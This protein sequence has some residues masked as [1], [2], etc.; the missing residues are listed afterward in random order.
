MPLLKRSVLYVFI[1]LRCTESVFV[2][3]TSCLRTKYI[4]II[5]RQLKLRHTI[6]DYNWNLIEPFVYVA[7]Q[8]VTQKTQDGIQ[9]NKKLMSCDENVRQ[10]LSLQKKHSYRLSVVVSA[11]FCSG[12]SVFCVLYLRF[13]NEFAEGA[14]HKQK[15]SHPLPSTPIIH[16]S[17][18]GW[19]NTT[20]LHATTLLKHV[21]A[22]AIV[23]KYRN[24]AFILLLVNCRS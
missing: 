22:I 19:S 5:N 13:N 11:I 3:W 18:R 1:N 7:L 9:I 12:K 21:S 20:A 14:V 8:Q 23:D 2:L 17:I 16:H 24:N 15:Q 6:S 4:I 10:A